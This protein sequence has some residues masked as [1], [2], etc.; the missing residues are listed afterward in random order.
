MLPNYK[1]GERHSQYAITT[2]N[3]RG[4]AAS[5]KRYQ[6]MA[7]LKRHNI[8]I[9]FLQETH[10]IKEGLT[11]LRTSWAGQIYGT[12]VST[13]A[14]GVLIWIARE[15]PYVVTNSIIDSGDRKSTRLNLQ[16]QR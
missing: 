6:V 1:R 7:Y 3:V 9:A 2:W 10:L 16:S 5:H 14:K 13:Y 12:S 4:L 15:V 8:Q 11:T